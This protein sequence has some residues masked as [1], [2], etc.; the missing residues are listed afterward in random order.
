MPGRPHPGCGQGGAEPKK[1]AE[2][3]SGNVAARDRFQGP[4]REK[5]ANHSQGRG[6]RSTHLHPAR[7]DPELT[8]LGQ[9]GIGSGGFLPLGWRMG[10][11]RELRP[12][13]QGRAAA[14][15]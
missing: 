15:K 6:S 9:A 1:T 7:S 2:N 12:S 8:A 10:G 13:W 11:S 3:R 5:R 14:G 4:I